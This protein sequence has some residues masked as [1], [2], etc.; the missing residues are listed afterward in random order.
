MNINW[1]A[2]FRARRFPQLRVARDDHPGIGS[3]ADKPLDL[4]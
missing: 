3:H 4:A 2:R 1:S